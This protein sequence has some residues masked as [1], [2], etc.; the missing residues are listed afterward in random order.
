M[1]K[2]IHPLA[3]FR[4]IVRYEAL[5]LWR[6]RAWL[7]CALLIIPLLIFMTNNVAESQDW[8]KARMVVESASPETQIGLA[9]QAARA[10]YERLTAIGFALFVVA[11]FLFP[12]LFSDGI[13]KDGKYRVRELWRSLPVGT[14]NYLVGKTVAAMG[15][16]AFALVLCGAAGW[17]AWSILVYPVP[18]PAFIYAIGFPVVPFVM[19]NT[20]LVL[21]LTATQRTRRAAMLLSV[22]LTVGII[23]LLGIGFAGKVDLLEYL[24]PGRP[25]TM[26]F[27]YSNF[28]KVD[29]EQIAA[30]NPAAV[31]IFEYVSPLQVGISVAIAVAQLALVWAV[32]R[33]MKIH[34]EERT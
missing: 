1:I 12:I 3:Q 4:G 33:A 13:A 10:A 6:E 32:M 20:G 30:I 27:Y 18:L 19:A 14:G 17:I 21:L 16:V 29:L 24:N 15:M 28:F 7:F 8:Y 22:L 25:L 23:F 26:R 9:E 5:Q 31:D 34:Q 2:A 11:M